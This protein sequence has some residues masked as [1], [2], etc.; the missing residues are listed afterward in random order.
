MH[1]RVAFSG[2]FERHSN[3]PL[4]STFLCSQGRRK[5]SNSKRR[6]KERQKSTHGKHRMHRLMTRKSFASSS[7]TRTADASGTH[8]STRWNRAPTSKRGSKRRSFLWTCPSKVLARS[9]LRS[10]RLSQFLSP[11][12][13]NGITP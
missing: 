12:A 4:I 9:F 13:L 1:R 11:N 5:S 3:T 8:G 10:F 7:L 2:I 6:I